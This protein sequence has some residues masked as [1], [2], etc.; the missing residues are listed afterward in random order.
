MCNKML[1]KS[2][3]RLFFAVLEVWLKIRTCVFVSV[4]PLALRCCQRHF[5]SN[6]HIPPS[7]VFLRENFGFYCERVWNQARLLERN[8]RFIIHSVQWENEVGQKKRLSSF[9]S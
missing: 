6:I 1:L 2:F 4:L 7:S 5:Y 8:N 9:H 3:S